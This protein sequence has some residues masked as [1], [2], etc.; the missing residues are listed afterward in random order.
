MNLRGLDERHASAKPEDDG[1]VAILFGLFCED[2]ADDDEWPFTSDCLGSADDLVDII[3][4]GVSVV[5][6]AFPSD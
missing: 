5:G 2:S 1:V 4:A 6:D 3:L